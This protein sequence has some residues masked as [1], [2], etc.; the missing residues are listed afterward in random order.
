MIY[1]DILY[2]TITIYIYKHRNYDIIYEIVWWCNNYTLWRHLVR[3]RCFNLQTSPARDAADV[4][5]A[6]SCLVMATPADWGISWVFSHWGFWWIW[7]SPA[8]DLW[9][10]NWKTDFSML[11]KMG[12]KR[13][14]AI[15][16]RQHFVG[17]HSAHRLGLLLSR[18]PRLAQMRSVEQLHFP[19][20]Q[21]EDWTTLWKKDKTW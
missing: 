17:C 12:P 3:R 19:K 13:G 11:N 9:T 6:L 2:I 14:F 16:P 18:F 4:E 7:G 8:G 21:S 10:K 20:M 15:E 1:Y 5:W